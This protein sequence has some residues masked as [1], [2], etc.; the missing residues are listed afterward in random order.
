MNFHLEGVAYIA[1]GCF[2]IGKQPSGKRMTSTWI[3]GRMTTPQR[4]ADSGHSWR[5]DEQKRGTLASGIYFFGRCLWD[6]E[7]LWDLCMCFFV[8]MLF[9][10]RWASWHFMNCWNNVRQKKR[11]WRKILCN[12][13]GTKWR[14]E[15]VFLLASLPDDWLWFIFVQQ[16]GVDNIA[17]L[18]PKSAQ[19][20]DKTT[21]QK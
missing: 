10:K 9:I 4:R 15:W 6:S 2:E 1:V 8:L 20:K 5:S 7:V 14:F 13:C 12:L 21:L 18:K 17:E 3:S 16:A 11:C 19:K